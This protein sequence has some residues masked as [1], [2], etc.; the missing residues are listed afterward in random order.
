MNASTGFCACAV[1]PATPNIWWRL[2]APTVG[3]LGE[4]RG[5]CPSCGARRM[6]E[7]AALLVDNAELED[8]L[9]FGKG[10]ESDAG[11]NRNGY[12]SKT[13]QTEDGQFEL[14]TPRDRVG[15]YDAWIAQA[16]GAWLRS[17]RESESR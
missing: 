2:A 1:S 7:S 17:V 10:E 16:G 15:S 3:A 11:N 5:F 6:A 13:L 4:R 9:G 14:D 8:H 12:T